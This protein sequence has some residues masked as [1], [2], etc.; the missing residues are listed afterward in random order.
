M[1]TKLH[2]FFKSSSHITEYGT[3]TLVILGTFINVACL[4][5][6]EMYTR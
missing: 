5:H 3:E 1:V 6:I 2:F 4:K